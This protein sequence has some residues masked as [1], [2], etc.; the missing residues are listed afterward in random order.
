V[1]ISADQPAAPPGDRLVGNWLLLLCAMIFGM[2]VGGG[3]ARTIGASFALETWQPI[4]GFIPPLTPADWT[5]LFGLFQQTAIYQSH[6]MS[7]AAFKTLFW[8]MFLDRCWGRLMALVFLLPFAIFCWRRR[9]STRLAIWLLAIFASGGAQAAF[10]WYMVETG[11]N[12]GVLVPPPLWAAPH[13]L[14]AMLIFTALLWT[15]LTVRHPTPAPVA[16]AVHLRVAATASIFLIL[17]TMLFGGLVAAT[18][19]ITVYNTFPLMDGHLIPTKIFALHPVLQNF[20]TNQATVQFFHRL[21]ATI[22]ALTVLITAIL[23][24]ISRKPGTLQDS[25][26]LLAGLVA[27]QYFLGMITLILAAPNLGF[28]HELNAVLLLAAAILVRHNL[29]GA[30]SERRLKLTNPALAGGAES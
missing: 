14:S 30:I 1:K 9:I 3:H 8:P 28:I 19:A 2:V 12:P 17:G 18:N 7:L 10:G 27:L 22:T 15:A 25:F 21:L 26:L 20:I 16:N 5:H 13:L 29:R 6:P 24:L 4:T 23:G 11:L